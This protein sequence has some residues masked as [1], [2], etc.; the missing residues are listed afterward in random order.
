MKLSNLVWSLFG[1]MALSACSDNDVAEVI[2]QQTP[3]NEEGTASQRFMSVRI[4]NPAGTKS[5]TEGL[6]GNY[7]K[8]DEG[9]N[10][11][12]NLRF[13][14]FN[15]N[16]EAVSVT[17][18]TTELKTVNYVDATTITKDN[19]AMD[20][21]SLKY[22]A[23]VVLNTTDLQNSVISQMVAVAN[24]DEN[25]L[26]SN[27]MSLDE[28]CAKV[29]NYSSVTATIG[30]ETKANFLMT[31]SSYAKD[32]KQINTASITPENLRLSEAEAELHPVDIYIERVVAKARMKTSIIAKGS[33]S[34]YT[35]IN[36]DTLFALSDAEGHAI[37]IKY[38]NDEQAGEGEQVY[39]AFNNWNVTGTANMSY[40]FKKVNPSWN[41]LGFIWNNGDFF[42]SFW[43]TNPTNNGNGTDFA[44]EY[45]SYASITNKLGAEG[46]AYC[47][48]NAA[49]DFDNGTKA[50][51]DPV[52][53]TTNRT[54]AIIAA[55][56]MTVKNGTATALDL[57][58]WG[59][60]NY[61]KE[62]VK[63]AM[64][65]TVAS[66]I[67][68]K[69]GEE[70][71][72]I[73]ET[74]VQLV[75]AQSI[76]QAN[77]LTENSPRYLS[78]LQLSEGNTTQFYSSKSDDATMTAQEVNALLALIPGARVWNGGMTYYYTDLRHLAPETTNAGYYGVVRNH[79]YD[80]KISKVAGLGTP[81]LDDTEKIIPQKPV[82][83][84]TFI[85]AQINILSWRVVSNDTELI[86]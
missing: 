54:Q 58:K 66:Q 46:K 43:A 30:E 64:L 85:A 13:Y 79:I 3:G 57:A 68:K 26:G 42:R 70:F 86:W 8:G 28:L 72:S 2:D 11:I 52:A 56:L 71:V 27:S 61:T 39:V 1:V 38:Q 84:E 74:E 78:C 32:N 69:N 82:N 7:E 37:K 15:N 83:D 18:L 31:S 9:E 73:D 59:G 40:L 51:Y 34:G 12:N 33:T 65:G 35:V 53:T 10:A 41:N 50:T 19:P 76:G 29:D 16:G 14:F 24:F 23:V 44:L 5:N 60:M 62:N 48:E 20:N 21:V 45:D 6:D 36:G 81:V 67:Y 80:V 77:Y 63:K 22:K 49:D 75:T 17:Q 47:Q 4:S 55:K 25:K